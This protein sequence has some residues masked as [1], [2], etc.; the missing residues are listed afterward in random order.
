MTCDQAL[1]CEHRKANTG[2]PSPCQL[3]PL[4]LGKLGEL[5]ISY[6]MLSNITKYQ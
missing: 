5:G 6:L 4:Y 3:G 1:G 2:L